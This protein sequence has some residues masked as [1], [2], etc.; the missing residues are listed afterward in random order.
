VKLLEFQCRH[1]YAS[2]F[3]LDLAFSLDSSV[4]ALLGPSGSGKTT[5]LEFIAGVRRPQGGRICLGER[6]LFDSQSNAWLAPEAR[7]IGMVFQDYLLFPHLTVERNLRYG[8][9]RRG[10][11]TN[12]SVD[13]VAKL[14]DLDTLL[15]RYPSTLSGGQRQRT[16]L[17]R[18]LLS[19]PQLLLMD[20]PL[21]AQDSELKSRILDY[22]ERIIDELAVSVLMVTHDTGWV[23][24]LSAT[25]LQLDQGRLVSTAPT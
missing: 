24:K 13:Q 1:R 4:T 12:V 2:G 15:A 5:V 23:T 8:L 9:A 19:G 14:L 3:Q 10:R 18:A 22:L 16:A 7:R 25:C 6:V 20:E 21:N 17:G 11:L